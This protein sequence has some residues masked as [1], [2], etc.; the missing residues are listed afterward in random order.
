MKAIA[1][2]TVTG[3]AKLRESIEYVRTADAAI[4]STT[5]KTQVHRPL[6]LVVFI[7]KVLDRAH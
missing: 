4:A 1:Y 2:S 6:L 7:V 3:L 5:S